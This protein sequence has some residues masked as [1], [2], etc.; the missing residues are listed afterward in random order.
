MQ[1]VNS[2]L[3]IAQQDNSPENCIRFCQRIRRGT[4]KHC[5]RTAHCAVTFRE[6]KWAPLETFWIDAT[7]AA[8]LQKTNMIR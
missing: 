6:Q 2:H 8:N 1:L 7:Q 3:R 4:R 5:I